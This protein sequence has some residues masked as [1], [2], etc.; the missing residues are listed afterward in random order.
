MQPPQFKLPQIRRA[1]EIDVKVHKSSSA[2][3]NHFWKSL[4]SAGSVRTHKVLEAII[5]FQRSSG[6]VVSD[7]VRVF[8]WASGIQGVEFSRWEAIWIDSWV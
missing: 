3:L 7:A 1:F 5:S 2:S 6:K 8:L 4:S